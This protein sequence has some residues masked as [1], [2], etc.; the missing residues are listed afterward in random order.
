M[1]LLSVVIFSFLLI[2]CIESDDTKKQR[3]LLKG[4]EKLNERE[5]REAI[6]YYNEAVLI[7]PQYADALNN[8]GVAYSRLGQD[9]QAVAD[10]TNATMAE[11]DRMDVLYNRALSSIQIKEYYSA[12]ADLEVIKK[13]YPDTPTVHFTEGLAQWQL[14]KYPEAVAAFNI[15]ESQ[16]PYNAE[17]FI[18]RAT[19]FYYQGDFE[20]AQIDL[21]KGLVLDPNEAN[22]Y[23]VKGLIAEK[24][25]NID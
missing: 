15:A 16:D 24:Q 13:V 3:F 2:G 23:N 14:K 7:D 20:K 17:I 19:L 5:Y 12:L 22:A 18:N 8:R 6:R 21:N 4:N 11:P 9:A 1:R 10:F 25:G